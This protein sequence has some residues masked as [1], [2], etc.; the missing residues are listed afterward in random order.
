MDWFAGLR[1]TII[2]AI[3]ASASLA[4]SGRASLLDRPLPAHY[5]LYAALSRYRHTK[6]SRSKC[7]IA[8][9][10]LPFGTR[11]ISHPDVP[12]D[13]RIQF[14]HHIVDRACIGHY[15]IF[16]LRTFF[17]QFH[18]HVNPSPLIAYTAPKLRKWR[19]NYIVRA[20]DPPFVDIYQCDPTD[21]TVAVPAP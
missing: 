17:G 20:S 18:V 14:V 15:A 1:L 11:V 13:S 8:H 3:F 19:R 7:R 12:F 5:F 21:F 4:V 9:A 2:S 16:Q 10:A 6:P